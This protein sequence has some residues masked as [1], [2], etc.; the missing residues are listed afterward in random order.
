MKRVT[1]PWLPSQELKGNIR[2]FCR[3]RPALSASDVALQ[4][5]EARGIKGGKSW[6]TMGKTIGK[7]MRKSTINGCLTGKIIELNGACSIGTFDYQIL[8]EG[9]AASMA[10]SP[11]YRE[12]LA[13]KNL[14]TSPFTP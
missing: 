1:L 7:S 6:K 4:S 9:V 3:V 8:P 11:G 13:K 5:A 14:S 12:T 2:V 10:Q